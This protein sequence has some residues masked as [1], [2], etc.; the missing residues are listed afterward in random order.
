MARQLTKRPRKFFFKVEWKIQDLWVGVFW[1]RRPHWGL[2]VWV[3][4]IPTL[5]FHF[6]WRRLWD[7]L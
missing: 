1:E 7:W 3:C 5:P 6:G 2:D 4:I